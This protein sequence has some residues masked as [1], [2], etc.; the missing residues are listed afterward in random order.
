MG[1]FPK[2]RIRVP[3]TSANLGPGFDLMGMALK[4]YNEFDFTFPK[5]D[6]FQSTLKSGDDLPFHMKDDLVLSAYKDYF[7]H[8]LPSV[9]A[10]KYHCKMDLGLPLKGGLGSSAS[11]IV[12]GL[13][14]GR[15]V[16][17]A[18]KLPEALPKENDFLQFLAEWEGHPD[19]TL[20]AYLGGFVFAT[21]TNGESLRYFRKKF[22]ASIALFIL[23]PKYSVSTEESRK[24]LPQSYTTA[25][26]I[27]NL[28]RLGAWMHFLDK[29]KFS[30]L[31]VALQ[32]K[33]HTP[34]RIPAGSLLHKISL[35]LDREH[36]GHCLSGSGPSLLIFMER[37]NVASLLP[38]LELE[39]NREMGELNV[40]YNFQRVQTDN[41]G[42]RVTLH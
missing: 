39:M 13:C 26:V 14:L 23:T 7:E 4:I 34:Y 29:R 2:I 24:S 35:I 30:D 28:S 20:P 9:T 42:T 40:A 21:S 19:N 1:N 5:T 41:I 15:E 10:P 17:R 38:K 27:F 37:K 25:D 16:H 12:A 8:F 31:L 6:S 32:D 11:A 3:A 22:P 33:M 36:L 18:M